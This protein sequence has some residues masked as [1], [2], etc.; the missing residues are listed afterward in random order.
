MNINQ[1]GDP[2]LKQ[3]LKQFISIM[4]NWEKGKDI[5]PDTVNFILMRMNL[6]LTQLG[7]KNEED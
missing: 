5:D 2:Y 6:L 1:L 7:E 4:R 3:E